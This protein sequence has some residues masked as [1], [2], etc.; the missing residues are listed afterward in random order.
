MRLSD[1]CVI[2]GAG[3]VIWLTVVSKS[4]VGILSLPFFSIFFFFIF[5]FFSSPYSVSP[6][7][8]TFSQLWTFIHCSKSFSY[9]F[10]LLFPTSLPCSSGEAHPLL[11]R[12]KQQSFNWSPSCSHV[13]PCQSTPHSPSI[14]FLSHCLHYTTFL[15]NI[16]QF[17]FQ[18]LRLGYA[19]VHRVSEQ[20]LEQDCRGLNLS[21]DTNSLWGLGTRSTSLSL[22]F[23]TCQVG[24]TILPFKEFYDHIIC[25]VILYEL[26][27]LEHLGKHLPHFM[28]V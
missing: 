4:N 13:S 15:F 6:L 10:R 8:P 17:C 25:Y 7:H 18:I 19:A 3:R 23:L 28:L 16:L 22:T 24:K 2:S 11:I 20:S 14:M 12:D 27:F 26:T 9:S 1:L 21:S 5:L